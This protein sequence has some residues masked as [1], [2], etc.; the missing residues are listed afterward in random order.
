MLTLRTT[1]AIR[2]PFDTAK[3]G[4]LVSRRE[5]ARPFGLAALARRPGA[6]ELP[7]LRRQR[8]GGAG[9]DGGGLEAALP[10][11][12]LA[13][14]VQAEQQRPLRRRAVAG[15]PPRLPRRVAHAGSHDPR[16]R[17]GVRAAARARLGRGRDGRA[18]LSRVAAR[19]RGRR[20][21]RRDPGDRAG[22]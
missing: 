3:R 13:D 14:V 20:D 6:G 5:R 4:W 15:A 22:A 10:P 2:S 21:A 8:A 9:P 19:A 11:G 7:D 17:E 18:R 16:D 1:G 12:P